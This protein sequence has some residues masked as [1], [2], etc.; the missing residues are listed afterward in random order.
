MKTYFLWL[1]PTGKTHEL[2]AKTI[3][4][5]SQEHG[6]PLFDPHVTILG[7]IAGQEEKLIH[8]TEKLAHCL[9]PFD[10][11]LT[12][13]EFQDQYFQCVFMRVEETSTL[14]EAHTLARK[15]FHKEDAPPYMPHLSLLYGSYARSLKEQIIG[16]VS[17]S[18]SVQFTASAVTLFRVEGSSPKDWRKVRTFGFSGHDK[19]EPSD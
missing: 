2:L 8:Q 13:P 1:E 6:G 16:T 12:V 3:A 10:L 17:T 18:L 5:L 19:Q 9:S 14:L 11:T 4:H 7:D 15:V